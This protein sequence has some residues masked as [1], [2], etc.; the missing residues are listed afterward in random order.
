MLQLERQVWAGEHAVQRERFARALRTSVNR[1]LRPGAWRL[2]VG[3]VTSPRSFSVTPEPTAMV[4][5]TS[6]SAKWAIG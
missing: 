1:Y 6:A 5:S 2:A 3:S 4:L